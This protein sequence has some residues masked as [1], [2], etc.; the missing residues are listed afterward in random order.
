MAQNRLGRLYL[1]NAEGVPR[2]QE[3]GM[4]WVRAAAEQGHSPAEHTMGIACQYGDAA[5]GAEAAASWFARAAA[6]GIASSQYEIGVAYVNGDGV[7]MDRRQGIEWLWLAMQQGHAQAKADLRALADA[8]VFEWTDGQADGE[9]E[10]GAAVGAEHR[11]KDE[12]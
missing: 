7:K 11:N 1:S 9:A 10:G 4:R 2:D 8:G 3:R 12:V 5:G 6:A